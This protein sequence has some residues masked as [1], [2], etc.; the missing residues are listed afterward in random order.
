MMN[1]KNLVINN[2]DELDPELSLN[3]LVPFIS[4]A[5]Y[6]WLYDAEEKERVWQKIQKAMQ[7]FERK[8]QQSSSSSSSSSP[9]N[10]KEEKKTT[11]DS[12]GESNENAS[13][14][15][16]VPPR[17]VCHWTTSLEDPD[18]FGQIGVEIVKNHKEDTVEQEQQQQQ[19]HREEN[20]AC[21]TLTLF[22]ILSGYHWQ[23]FGNQLWAPSRHISNQLAD[24]D[25]CHELLAPLFRSSSSTSRNTSDHPLTGKSFVE[26]GAGAGLPSWTAMRRGARVVATDQGVPGRIRCMAECAARNWNEVVV[27]SAQQSKNDDDDNDNEQRIDEGAMP[28][29]SGFHRPKVCPHN[30]GTPVDAV[31]QTL[32]GDDDNQQN[33]VGVVVDDPRFDIVIAAD[34]C[35]MPWFYPELLTSI[36]RLLSDQG[37]AIL[38]FGLHGNVRD[39]EVWSLLD[40]ARDGGFQV[41]QLKSQQMTPQSTDMKLKQGLVHTIRLTRKMAN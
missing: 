19:E 27:M 33:D 34:C 30:W 13:T 3:Q 6:D 24:A 2:Y 7:F 16:V 1:N 31:F 25:Q 18:G 12:N 21:S 38:S 41:E 26:L 14:P 20:T 17:Q 23:G 37:V 15:V 11:T 35:F 10:S 5:T 40:Q 8:T 32:Y 4:D 36:D 9:N 28:L 39:D 29:V 22:Y